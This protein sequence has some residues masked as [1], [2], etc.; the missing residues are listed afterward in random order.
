MVY[1]KLTNFLIEI[2][3]HNSHSDASLFKF[4]K[5]SKI[6]W[7]LVY[8][9]DLIFTSNCENAL[10]SVINLLCNKFHHRDLGNLKYILGIEVA[11]YD[12]NQLHLNQSKYAMELY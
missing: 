9:D 10:K 12:K 1:A 5:N 4:N 11:R 3:F 6:I 2:G 7:I 8:T